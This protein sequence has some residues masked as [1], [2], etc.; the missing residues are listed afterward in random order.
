MRW[1]LSTSVVL[2]LWAEPPVQLPTYRAIDAEP[3]P[4]GIAL[5]QRRDRKDVPTSGLTRD[6]F[7]VILEKKEFAADVVEESP[8]KPGHY[9]IYFAPPAQFRNGKVH[10]IR[11]KV[12]SGGKWKTLPTKWPTMLPKKS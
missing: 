11:L 3:V 2:S 7:I 9:T 5:F 1:L 6:D 10:D 8:D 12:R 4:V